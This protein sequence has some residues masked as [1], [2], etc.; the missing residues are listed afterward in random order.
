MQRQ[1]H[2]TQAAAGYHALVLGTLQ[3]AAVEVVQHGVG[4]AQ[5]AGLHRLLCRPPR[6]AEH[7]DLERVRCTCTRTHQRTQ[8]GQVPPP[9][10]GARA[11]SEMRGADTRAD[12][13]PPVLQRLVPG[14]AHT[15]TGRAVQPRVANLQP[16]SPPQAQ[17]QAAALAP[18]VNA[19]PSSTP[20]GHTHWTHGHPET[21]M[22]T[23]T[24]APPSRIPPCSGGEACPSAPTQ[25]RR[26][27][28]GCRPS[29]WPWGT[30]RAAHPSTR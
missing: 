19:E 7:A 14:R 4:G 18:M 13:T 29:A 1:V 17:R 27:R 2:V 25:W 9:H 5:G 28:P 22:H 24:H 30:P 16:A 20:I 26:S 8:R 6:F 23:L 11:G 12:R 21:H 3:D 15:R 10:A